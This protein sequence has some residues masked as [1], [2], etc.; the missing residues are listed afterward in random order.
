MYYAPHIN[1]IILTLEWSR[2]LLSFFFS[3]CCLHYRPAKHLSVSV[4]ITIPESS[5]PLACAGSFLLGSHIVSSYYSSLCLRDH[6]LEKHIKDIKYWKFQSLKM[7]LFSLDIW[8][9]VCP[10][11]DSWIGVIFLH[12]FKISVSLLISGVIANGP[13]VSEEKTLR[14]AMGI[15]ASWSSVC[16][17]AESRKGLLS[18]GVWSFYRCPLKWGFA[19]HW[20]CPPH[21]P[22]QSTWSFPGDLGKWDSFWLCSSSFGNFLVFEAVFLI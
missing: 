4:F 19:R 8:L 9:T 17:F 7:D 13:V 10:H 1:S 18:H 21:A 5:F 16:D 2:C 12:N 22:R 3:L 15:V 20:C 14:P 11:I 6:T